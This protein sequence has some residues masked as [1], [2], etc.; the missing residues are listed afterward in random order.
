VISD[1]VLIAANSNLSHQGEERM[2]KGIGEYLNSSNYFLL[3]TYA[4]ST[5]IL[6]QWGYWGR[7]DVNVLQFMS[8]SE[9]LRSAAYPFVG[10]LLAFG[11]G[12]LVSG[13]GSKAKPAGGGADSKIG[14]FLRSNHEP[15]T[16]LFVIV[17]MV[18]FVFC[19]EYRW[20]ASGSVLT[21]VAMSWAAKLDVLDGVFPDPKLRQ[22]LLLFA[23]ST[24]ILSFSVGATNA[25]RILGGN[26]Y[27]QVTIGKS[28]LTYKYLGHAG[29]YAFLMSMDNKEIYMEHTS[30]LDVLVLRRVFER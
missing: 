28:G 23:V 29:E 9:I 24:P 26:S 30:Q 6:Y 27:K 16:G 11:A 18:L 8:L 12:I 20:V 4:I 15:L 22:V 7:F 10:S 14:K 25:E 2:S 19:G 21:I 5:S 17:A 1:A 13:L 3:S